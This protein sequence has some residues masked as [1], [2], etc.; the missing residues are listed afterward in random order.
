MPA[1]RVHLDDGTSYIT[2]MAHGVTLSDASAYLVGSVQTEENAETGKETRRIVSSVELIA[3]DCQREGFNWGGKQIFY[4][5]AKGKDVSFNRWRVCFYYAPCLAHTEFF[6]TQDGYDAFLAEAAKHTFP[7]YAEYRKWAESKGVH[8]WSEHG[9][10]DCV[11]ANSAP[12]PDSPAHTPGPWFANDE[13]TNGKISIYANG[14]IGYIGENAEANAARI[15][16]CVNACEG[17]ADPVAQIKALRDALGHASAKLECM[18]DAML[19][20]RKDGLPDCQEKT[21]VYT[22][23]KDAPAIVAIASEALANFSEGG[24]K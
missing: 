17:M 18:H 15:V 7:T 8:G 21:F 5:E 14:P 24:A 22:W 23:L 19:K 1:F 12:A 20:C 6:E 9:A 13:M 3:N 2:S 10:N 16:A 11:K 4:V